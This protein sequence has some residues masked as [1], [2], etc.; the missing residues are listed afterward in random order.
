M[1]KVTLITVAII[2]LSMILV[3]CG[4]EQV[5]D[6]ISQAQANGVSEERI[7]QE[8]QRNGISRPAG[9][10]LVGDTVTIGNWE[11]TVNSWRIGQAVYRAD[12]TYVFVSVTATN[13][14]SNVAQFITF[15][16]TH[17]RDV[18]VRYDNNARFMADAIGAAVEVNPMTSIT[19]ELRFPVANRAVQSDGLLTL[20]FDFHNGSATFLLRDPNNV[21]TAYQ[22]NVV[23]TNNNLCEI[24]QQLVGNTWEG[25]MRTLTFNADGTG[26]A[27]HPLLPGGFNWSVNGFRIV[28]DYHDHD[29]VTEYQIDDISTNHLS[30][31]FLFDGTIFGDDFTR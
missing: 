29:V 11:M 3:G 16:G 7:E 31:S 21:T 14:G 9:M 10:N 26:Y 8:L 2:T 12:S 30:V 28:V 19:N 25:T 13:N 1:K 18:W 24:G 23:T 17:N 6:A 20:E 15:G 27:E 4:E 22:S 5:S